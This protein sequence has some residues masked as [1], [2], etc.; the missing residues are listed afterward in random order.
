[1]KVARVTFTRYRV[2]FRTLFVTA[3]GRATHREGLLL[4]L[5]TDV[6]LVG[7]GEV[8]PLP[9]FDGAT[10]ADCLAALDSL[11]P[12]LPGLPLAGLPLCLDELPGRP[13]P[14]A[15]RAALDV[16][17]LDAIGRQRGVPVAELF[18]PNPRREVEANATIPAGD[19]TATVA[20]AQRAADAGYRTLKLKV[21]A[22]P[23]PHDVAIVAAVREALPGHV[24]RLDANGAW[25]PTAAA[26]ALDAFAPYAI[27]LLEQPV[28][29][30]QLD[31][32]ARL[33]RSSPIPLGADESVLGLEAAR[34]ALGAG[35]AD[36]L[37]V[38]PGLAG[39][40]T[41]AHAIAQLA[42]AAGVGTIITTALEVGPGLAAAL[43]T[44]ALLPD[45]C[46][47]CGLA[48]ASLFESTAVRGLAPPTPRMRLPDGP[49]LGVERPA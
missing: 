32:M 44:A 40:V 4:R 24:L 22:G 30:D 31:A 2:P 8:A 37:I 23:L 26:R 33:R 36:W 16:A 1:V 28:A 27:E 48:T 3:H 12:A 14:A 9:E 34:R 43:H 47:A 7:L 35:A 15:V 41:V 17:T 19:P 38:K 10:L 45:G 29:A 49:G 11:A 39:G 5:T 20:A 46:P 21:G 6:G 18:D 42:R 25:D 13:V